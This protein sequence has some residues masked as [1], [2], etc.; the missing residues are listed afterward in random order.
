MALYLEIDDFSSFVYS[1]FQLLRA[2]KRED[3]LMVLCM[4]R[5]KELESNHQKVIKWLHSLIII[6]YQIQY[7]HKY[8]Q[9]TWDY[10]NPPLVCTDEMREEWNENSNLLGFWKMIADKNVY[11]KIDLVCSGSTTISIEEKIRF[12]P[13]FAIICTHLNKLMLIFCC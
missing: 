7:T 12:E 8:S 3:K 1:V 2:N 11:I 9:S 10:Q 6:S 4:N 13:S 5:I